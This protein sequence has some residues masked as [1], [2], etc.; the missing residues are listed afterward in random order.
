MN[1]FFLWNSGTGSYIMHEQHLY[2]L[3]NLLNLFNTVFSNDRLYIYI[4]MYEVVIYSDF[5][6]LGIF[7]E[8]LFI[9]KIQ[10][11]QNTNGLYS[12]TC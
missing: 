3:F 5:K 7:N 6:K 10:F 1:I 4:C 11:C 2:I 8:M 12:E 9:P